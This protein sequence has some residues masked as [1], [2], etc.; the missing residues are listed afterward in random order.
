MPLYRL[1]QLNAAE[2]VV[3]R[4]ELLCGTD[5]EAIEAALRLDLLH[6]IEVWT[7]ARLVA[8]LYGCRSLSVFDRLAPA[9]FGMPAGA[10]GHRDSFQHVKESAARPASACPNS[11]L[12]C[13][14]MSYAEKAEKYLAKAAEC[15]KQVDQAANSAIREQY[16]TLGDMWM[17]LADE[18]IEV[19]LLG[20][21]DEIG[22]ARQSSY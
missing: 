14:I 2:R 22:G 1:Y 12:E 9:A 11:A 7:S 3:S 15:Y 6:A 4:N 5:K 20:S 8:K 21:Q 10:T 18:Q 13:E 16:K 17:E 19:V